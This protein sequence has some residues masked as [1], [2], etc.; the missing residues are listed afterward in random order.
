[1]RKTF[2]LI[3]LFIL[4]ITIIFSTSG[5][6]DDNMDNIEIYVTNYA[7]EYITKELYGNHATVTSIY[8]DGIDINNYVV[9]QKQKEDY[10]KSDLF[11]YNGLIERERNMA[12][13]LLTINPELK[14]IDSSDVLETD[15][16]P[17]ELWLNPSSLLM[18]AQN[19]RIG[20]QEYASSTYL[21]KDID[22]AYEELK[23][24]LSELDADYRLTVEN[25]NNKMI[26]VDNS[27]LKYLEKFGLEVYCIDGDATE[28]TIS[29]VKNL[30]NDKKI[31]YIYTFKND[32]LSENA[33]NIMNEFSN[34]K[35]QEL[36]KL[37]NISDEQ[38]A[39]KETYDTLIVENLEM[40][41][42]ELY[43]G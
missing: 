31:N 3:L 41:K 42:Q 25:T 20:L 14:I 21:K 11:I 1:M 16:S 15:Y 35:R 22:T 30:I 18:M 34:I 17:E 13:D 29:D 12:I 40:L 27:A 7:N 24:K 32:K 36:H 2:K 39:N 9:S 33:T 28:K 23:I 26:V 19:I 43:Q 4:T 37:D 5:C 8:P 10:S 38:R 6:T